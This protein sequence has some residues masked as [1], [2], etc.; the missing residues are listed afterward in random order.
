MFVEPLT[1]ELYVK[2]R[3]H[4]ARGGHAA[5]VTRLDSGAKLLL[6]DDGT[7]E[8]TL[9]EAF[10][11][12]RFAAEAR[13]AMAAGLSRTLVLEGVRQPLERIAARAVGVPDP[14]EF[15]PRH[16]AF[17]GSAAGANMRLM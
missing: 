6:L 4:A 1:P 7:S 16:Q 2:V 5:I 11:D 17:V 13:E 9:G 15:D 10:L 3:E 8:G 12:E 14:F